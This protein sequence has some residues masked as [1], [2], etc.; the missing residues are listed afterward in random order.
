MYYSMLVDPPAAGGWMQD[1]RQA[2]LSI[3]KK[4]SKNTAFKE[5]QRRKQQPVVAFRQRGR[6]LCN[7]Q[8]GAGRTGV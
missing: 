6:T 1:Y 8:T 7:G 5:R 2:A 4:R 3:L